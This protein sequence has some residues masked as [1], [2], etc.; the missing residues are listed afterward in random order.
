[1]YNFDFEFIKRGAPIV[2]LSSLGIA[3]NHSSIQALGNPEKILIGYDA[4]AHV[5][6]VKKAALND[7]DSA[8]EFATRVKNDWVRI[9]CRD[10]VKK[11]AI[12]TEMNFDK[13]ATQFI[14]SYNNELQMLI[15][16]IDDKHK[17]SQK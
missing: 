6:G 4:D 1:M 15:I 16:T 2:T 3:F 11:L 5:I 9:G 7:Y 12:D 13:K 14:A 8:Y 17:K 10:F